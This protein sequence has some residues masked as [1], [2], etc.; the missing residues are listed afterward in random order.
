M[1]SPSVGSGFGV[2]AGCSVRRLRGVGFQLF[3]LQGELFDL[4][5]ELLAA[6]AKLQPLELQKQ[7]QLPA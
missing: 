4:R 5:V 1:S 7:Q 2:I 3:Q 6:A